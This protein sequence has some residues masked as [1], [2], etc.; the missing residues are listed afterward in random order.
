MKVTMKWT[1]EGLIRVMRTIDPIVPDRATLRLVE[2]AGRNRLTKPSGA[3]PVARK[4]QGN[5][6]KQGRNAYGRDA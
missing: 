3:V 6:K 4:A 5:R 2:A 1:L